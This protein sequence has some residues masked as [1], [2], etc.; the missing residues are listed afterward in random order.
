MVLSD[1]VRMGYYMNVSPT[2][3]SP[4]QMAPIESFAQNRNTT[5]SAPNRGQ[6]SGKR[7]QVQEKFRFVGVK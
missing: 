1:Y 3:F 7:P 2:L 4:S 6:C 5:N